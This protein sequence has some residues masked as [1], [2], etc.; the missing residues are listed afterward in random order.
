MYKYF[1]KQLD[2]AQSEILF[3]QIRVN[4]PEHTRYWRAK[5]IVPALFYWL[6]PWEHK[7][8][9]VYLDVCAVD[10]FLYM[11]LFVHLYLM[12]EREVFTKT[13]GNSIAL[14]KFIQA[15]HLPRPLRIRIP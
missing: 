4:N 13:L 9:N 14:T 10:L 11:L 15:L 7:G 8:N 6:K 12:N 1:L 5:T 3:P 2:K